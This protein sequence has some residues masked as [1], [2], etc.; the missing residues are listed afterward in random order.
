MRL[1]LARRMRIEAGL[2]RL[3][4]LMSAARLDDPLRQ[5]TGALE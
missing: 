1:L 5:R 4:E 3:G 2:T